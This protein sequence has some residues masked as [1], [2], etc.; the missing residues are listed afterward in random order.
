MIKVRKQS[1][2][3][4]Q[5]LLTAHGANSI[6]SEFNSTQFMHD[7]D[8]YAKNRSICMSDIDIYL[9]G[10]VV[11]IDYDGLVNHSDTINLDY[12]PEGLCLYPSRIVS[13]RNLVADNMVK[14]V[15]D[16]PNQWNAAVFITGEISRRVRKGFVVIH[17]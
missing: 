3:R 7:V 1:A 11:V 6:I 5:Q 17:R 16:H 9:C 10:D 12:I 8:D 15:C 13:S 14:I 2:H 4:I